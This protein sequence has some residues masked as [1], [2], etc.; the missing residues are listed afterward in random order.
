MQQRWRKK[1]GAESAPRPTTHRCRSGTTCMSRRIGTILCYLFYTV[2]E[3]DTSDE[4]GEPSG[5]IATS[6]SHATLSRNASSS[7]H[8]FLITTTYLSARC[9]GFGCH[10]LQVNWRTFYE[11]LFAPTQ[12]PHASSTAQQSINN[13]STALDYSNPSRLFAMQHS[14]AHICYPPASTSCPAPRK[15]SVFVQPPIRSNGALPQARERV[16][17]CAAASNGSKQEQNNRKQQQQQQQKGQ[18]NKPGAS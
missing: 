14:C 17:Q 2:L 13:Q 3:H 7:T 8:A 15:A 4:M 18:D 11:N 5:S 6:G 16:V 9:A 1:D 10:T 12:Q